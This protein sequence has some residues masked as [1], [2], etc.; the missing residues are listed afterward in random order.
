MFFS[1]IFVREAIRLGREQGGRGCKTV[2]DE[3]DFTADIRHPTDGMNFIRETAYEIFTN[4]SKRK[5]PKRSYTSKV[6]SLKS[7]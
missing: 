6:V 7:E 5:N 1:T 2:G 4:P 3:P